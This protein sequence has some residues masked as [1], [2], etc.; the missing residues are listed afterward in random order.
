MSVGSITKNTKFYFLNL[1]FFQ[2]LVSFTGELTGEL[3]RSPLKSDY[4]FEKHF[5]FLKKLSEV[6]MN[7]KLLT[8]KEIAEYLRL[9]KSTIYKLTSQKLIPFIKL[10]NGKVLF[11]LSDIEAW[12]E[13][14]KQNPVDENFE[15]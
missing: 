6:Y 13:K 11:K 12:L 10:N 15:L 14:R 7:D 8:A 1:L 3:R 4:F 9:S 5:C 2:I